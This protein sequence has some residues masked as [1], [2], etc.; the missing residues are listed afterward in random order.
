[1][2]RVLMYLGHRY[3]AAMIGLYTVWTPFS[4]LTWNVSTWGELACAAPFLALMLLLFWGDS[5]HDSRL[6]ERCADGM[7][8]DGHA[9]A[10]KRDRALRLWHSTR[11]TLV[12]VTVL[13]VSL[14]IPW[15]SGHLGVTGREIFVLQV[16]GVLTP[17]ITAPHLRRVHT[18]LYPWCKYCRH[19][20]GGGGWM[21][22]PVPDGPKVEEPA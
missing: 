19:G 6:C 3:V 9:A 10:E 12:L 18:Q 13:I 20:R 8:L 4:L 1:M 11:F 16:L 15:F 22:V 7:P 2:N 5:R 17:G 21:D 14:S